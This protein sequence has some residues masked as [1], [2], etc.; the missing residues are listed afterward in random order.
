MPS[1]ESQDW[2]NKLLDEEVLDRGRLADLLDEAIRE[3]ALASMQSA[4]HI[5]ATYSDSITSPFCGESTAMADC[6]LGAA[7]FIENALRVRLAHL[8]EGKP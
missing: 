4:V 3:A 5:A 2:A 8:R 1:K 7:K 6:M